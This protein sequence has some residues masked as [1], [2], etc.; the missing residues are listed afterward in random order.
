MPQGR[1]L[2]LFCIL[3]TL[4]YKELWGEDNFTESIQKK[5]KNK[6]SS[7]CLCQHPTSLRQTSPGT[8]R[9]L[10]QRV[11]TILQYDSN[12]AQLTDCTLLPLAHQF[13]FHTQN[14]SSKHYHKK[15]QDVTTIKH[16]KPNAL[17]TSQRRKT[18]KHL[19]QAG[20]MNN[21]WKKKQKSGNSQKSEQLIAIHSPQ[22]SDRQGK[23]SWSWAAGMDVTAEVTHEISTQAPGDVVFPSAFPSLHLCAHAMA[24][25]PPHTRGEVPSPAPATKASSCACNVWE[26]QVGGCISVQEVC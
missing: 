17:F 2:R 7:L 1:E 4:H 11:R 13:H 6:K 25:T 24:V 23:A 19:I 10:V 18:C 26:D 3:D 20:T 16:F 22:Q 12:K 14:C 21:K 15:I 9:S 5:I 8:G